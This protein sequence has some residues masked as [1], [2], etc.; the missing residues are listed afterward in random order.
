MS[1]EPL[2]QRFGITAAPRWLREHPAITD[3]EILLEVPLKPFCAWRTDQRPS[4]GKIPY[5][6]K[7]VAPDSEEAEIYDLLHQYDPASPNHTLP[8][9][10]IRDDRTILIMPCLE[11]ILIDP[12]RR[13]WDLVPMLDFFR[14]VV[15]G[16]EF[17]HRLNIAHMDMYDGQVIIATEREVAYHPQVEAG[18]VYIIDY[19]TSKR[20]NR[21]PGRQNA[22]EL[23]ETNCKPPLEMKC[24]DPYSWDIYCTGYLFKSIS[25]DVF[26][27]RPEPWILRKYTQWLIGQERGCTTVCHC[28]PSARRARL[29]LIVIQ[30][31]VHIWGF[32]TKPIDVVRNLLSPPVW[33]D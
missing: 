9:E 1:H 15:E 30:C 4:A 7:I 28:R 5:A 8:C 17:L 20:L 3:R 16:L 23:P 12:K 25:E 22:I 24:F 11:K 10:V 6:V 27:D 32:C 33:H 29:M 14:Q 21:G 26:F 31:V 13:A 2:N 19:G 18:K